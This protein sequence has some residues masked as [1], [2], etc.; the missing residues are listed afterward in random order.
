VLTVNASPEPV[1]KNHPVTV[2]G[3]L[4]RLGTTG[5]SMAYHPNTKQR[6]KI[7]FNPAGKA[8]QHYVT[9]TTTTTKGT[10]TKKIKQKVTGTW[11]VKY[12]G[13]GTYAADHASDTVKVRR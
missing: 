13:T 7:Y 3:S 4:K 8:P 6:V 9:S 5:Y 1:R 10:Y 12:A 2:R 11:T